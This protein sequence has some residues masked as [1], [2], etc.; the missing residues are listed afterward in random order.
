[1]AKNDVLKDYSKNFKINGSE[2]LP[3]EAYTEAVAIIVHTLYVLSKKYTSYSKTNFKDLFLVELNFSM[4]QI[5]KILKH[6][7]ITNISQ[8]DHRQSS[9]DIYIVQNTSIFSYFIIKTAILLNLNNLVTFFIPSSVKFNNAKID[10][11]VKFID[12]SFNNLSLHKCI[13]YYVKK[14]KNSNDNY[15]NETLRMSCLEV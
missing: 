3:N 15:I 11:F 10:T 2:V 6:Y 8:L 4:F 1:M 5:A 7:N 9:D 12:K 14:L 13:R